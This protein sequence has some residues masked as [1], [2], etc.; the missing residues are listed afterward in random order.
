[1]CFHHFSYSSYEKTL[2]RAAASQQNTSQESMA[3]TNY[4]TDEDCVLNSESEDETV[5]RS[6][7]QNK[8]CSNLNGLF[9]KTKSLTSRF[10]E[11]SNST[12][13]L[14]SYNSV[15][16][17]RETSNE[18][19]SNKSLMRDVDNND[20]ENKGKRKADEIEESEE[21]ESKISKIIKKIKNEEQSS[22]VRRSGKSTKTKQDVLEDKVHSGVAND[23]YVKIN[24]NK[25]VYARGKKTFTFSKFKKQQ[26]KSNKKAN[27]NA[28]GESGGSNVVTCFKCGDVGHWAR[29][30]MQSKFLS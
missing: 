15:V 13:C 3:D 24:I 25:K 4:D 16:A 9:N 19:L 14:P 21:K 28:S 8:S 20:M 29:N 23:N 22:V 30:C 11:K 17:N 12:S 26:W 2:Q 10:A 18:E 1:M 27:A 6:L 7:S 5:S